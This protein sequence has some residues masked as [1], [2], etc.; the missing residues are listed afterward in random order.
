MKTMV[1]EKGTTLTR[2]IGKYISGT[3]IFLFTLVDKILRERTQNSFK[4]KVQ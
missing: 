2:F 3:G 1:R 4:L